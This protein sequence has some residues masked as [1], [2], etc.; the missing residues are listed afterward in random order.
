MCEL[1]DLSPSSLP[2]SGQCKNPL[3]TQLRRYGWNSAIVL[4][5]IDGLCDGSSPAEILDIIA[6]N[7]PRGAF[8]DNKYVVNYTFLTIKMLSTM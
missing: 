2:I 3:Q 7:T 5:K 4:G 8:G 6:K 1:I